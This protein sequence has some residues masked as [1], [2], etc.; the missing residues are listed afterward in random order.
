MKKTVLRYGLYGGITIC[1]LFLLAWFMGN[2]LSYSLQEVIG[3]ISMV[4]S[5]SFVFFGIKH[6]RDR[7][8][9]GRVSFSKALAIGVLISLITALVFGVLDVIYVEYLNPEF[10]DDYYDRSIAQLRTT[11]PANEYEAKVAELEAEKELFMN[12]IF[13]FLIMGMTVFVIGF[14]ISLISSL[15]LQRN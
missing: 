5:L 6:F 15:I 14:I 13:S 12:P 4:V 1:V 7:E 3:Y 9:N 2:G 10:M 8:N 11:L